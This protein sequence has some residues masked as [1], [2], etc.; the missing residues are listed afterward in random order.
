MLNDDLQLFTFTLE[1]EENL[2]AFKRKLKESLHEKA[3]YE[4]QDY[5]EDES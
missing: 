5:Y 2:K 1:K 3:S 4:T